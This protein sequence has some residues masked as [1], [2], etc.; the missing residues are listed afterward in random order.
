MNKC[1]ICGAIASHTITPYTV[2]AEMVITAQT[3]VEMCEAH[4]MNLMYSNTAKLFKVVKK[5]HVYPDIKIKLD[6]HTGGYIG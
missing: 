3:S 5:A 2:N 1:S 4:A 6:G